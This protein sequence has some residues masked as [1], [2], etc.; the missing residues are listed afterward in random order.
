MEGKSWMT[1]CGIILIAIGIGIVF[2][3]PL[4]SSSVP[5][6]GWDL[7]EVR[8]LWS[9]ET[10]RPLGGAVFIVVG[11]VFLVRGLSANLNAGQN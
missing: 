4:F 6:P 8:P 9:E 10:L 11:M 2:W 1:K 7:S 3:H 5:Q